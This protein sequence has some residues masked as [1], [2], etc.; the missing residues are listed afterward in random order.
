MI[1]LPD[2]SSTDLPLNI[3]DPSSIN[4]ADLTMISAMAEYPPVTKFRK[5]QICHL[6]EATHFL[7]QTNKLIPRLWQIRFIISAWQ[8][9]IMRLV[10]GSRSAI[11]GID[12]AIALLEAAG[13]YEVNYGRPIMY[14]HAFPHGLYPDSA[15][16]IHERYL[17]RIPFQEQNQDWEV[18]LDEA[19]AP[20]VGFDAQG[21]RAPYTYDLAPDLY[22]NGEAIGRPFSFEEATVQTAAMLGLEEV[23]FRPVD[24]Y[25][26]SPSGAV[27]EDDRI[28]DIL[29]G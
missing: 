9:E 25:Y 11:Q 19:R 4:E 20:F 16:W 29:R 15:A 24:P 6:N 13:F 5:G 2:G 12:H 28:K 26:L 1:H 14:C 8:Y 17:T 27:C 22:Q 18:I 10:H 3:I 23:M 7:K 21:L